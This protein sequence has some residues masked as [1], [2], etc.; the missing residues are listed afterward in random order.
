MKKRIQVSIHADLVRDAERIM[1]AEKFQ[2]FSGFLEQ[3]IREE[4][5]RR[6]RGGSAGTVPGPHSEETNRLNEST[7]DYKIKRKKP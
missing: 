2:S 6:R 3:L 7:T 4:D 1:T 5:R